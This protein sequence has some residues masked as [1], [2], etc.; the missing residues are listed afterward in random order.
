MLPVKLPEN[1]NLKTKGNPLDN[2]KEWKKV[3]INGQEMSRARVSPA[4][5]G[6]DGLGLG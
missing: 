2:E 4:E 5:A 6:C 1:L 3:F